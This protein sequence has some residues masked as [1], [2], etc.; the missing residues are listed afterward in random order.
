MSAMNLPQREYGRSGL[1]VSVV[2]LG[3]GQIGDP[4]LDEARVRRLLEV[5]AEAGVTLIDTAPSYG[6]SEV[7]LGRLMGDFRGQFAVSTKLGYGVPGIEDWTGPCIAAGIEQALC[8]LQVERLDIAHLHSCP[9]HVLQR[10]DILRALE[11]GRRAGKV[12]AIAYSGENEA[13]AFARASGRFDGL[14]ASLNLF[15]QRLIESTLSQ[16]NGMGFIA[17]RPLANAPWRFD[18]LPQGDYCETYWRRWR[19]MNLP[20]PGM[21]WGEL[22]SRFAAWQTGVA[23]AVFGTANAEH[24]KQIVDWVAR[25]PLPAELLE[26]WRTAFRQHGDGWTGQI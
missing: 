21:P 13:L 5:A 26:C 16:L 3:A 2:G 4:A 22:A 20:D 10:D 24:F 8:R 11:D 9:L 17:K 18:S 14:M 12:R 7:R 23:S 15:D 6:L 19:T 1:S 25:G